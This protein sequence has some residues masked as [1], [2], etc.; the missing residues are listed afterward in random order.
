[1]DF[2]KLK[3][4]RKNAAELAKK[5]KDQKPSYIDDRF[6]KLTVDGQGNGEAVIRFLEIYDYEENDGMKR[7]LTDDNGDYIPLEPFK[8]RFEH[9]LKEGGKYFFDNCPI[10]IGEKCPSC[11]HAQH[12]FDQGTEAAKN[13]AFRYYRSKQY[14]ANI[15]ALLLHNLKTNYV[16]ILESVI[17]FK[18]F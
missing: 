5:L 18:L 6:W 4:Q 10:T 15:K 2:S 7:H 9:Q 13:I 11:E 3:K 8:L 1:M 17:I 14:I 16:I 12:Y